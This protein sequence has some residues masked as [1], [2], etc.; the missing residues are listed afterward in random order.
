[1][2]IQLREHLPKKGGRGGGREVIWAMPERK[3]SFLHEVFPKL[4]RLTH[5]NLTTHGMIWGVMWSLR[6]FLLL[7][8]FFY[9]SFIISFSFLFLAYKYIT[10]R[11]QR[12]LCNGPE[13]PTQ[14]K[15][16]SATDLLTDQIT[17]WPTGVG[18]RDLWSRIFVF[19]QLCRLCSFCL[20]AA[21]E[22]EKAL[23]HYTLYTL[24]DTERLW[25]S[26]HIWTYTTY[27]LYNTGSF[28]L[29]WASPKKIKY[30]KPRLGEST[31]T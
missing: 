4:G 2:W 28:F 21:E 3:H 5:A 10:P 23:V 27:N 11:G 9:F 12:T 14:W 25:C 22:C 19:L 13:T 30:G 29:H 16:E 17:N 31:L 20:C 7:S 1:M 24:H 8:S 15:A 18:A 26:L 6:N